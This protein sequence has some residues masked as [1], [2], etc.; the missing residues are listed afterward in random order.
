M[1]WRNI[2][3]SNPAKLYCKNRSLVIRQD[4]DYRV[5]FEDISS[6]IIDNPQ[7]LLTQPVLSNAAEYGI[8]IFSTDS[9]HTPNGIFVPFVQHN[10][11]LKILNLQLN[12][13][14]PVAKRLRSAIISAKIHNQ[15]QCL[16]INGL[17]GY[18]FIDALSKNVRSGDPDNVEARA[19]SQYFKYLFGDRFVRYDECSAINSC[20]NYGYAV[21]RG[22]VARRLVTHGLHPPLGIFHCNQKNSFNLADDLIEPYRPIVDIFTWQYLQNHS[23]DIEFSLPKAGLVNLLNYDVSMPEGNMAVSLAVEYTVESYV[24]VLS[25][26]SQKISLPE[27][28]SFVQHKYQEN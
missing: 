2:I 10:S 11:S 15:A 22:E 13:P 26:P 6:I 8:A 28:F 7:V 12:C 25:D 19:A 3:I 24:R 20:L 5:P 9:S 1:S 27:I 23:A 4:Y 14:K 21:I 17:G 18:D 16:R